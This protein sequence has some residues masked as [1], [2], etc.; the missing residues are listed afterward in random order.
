MML[1]SQRHGFRG[2]SRAYLERLMWY[3]FA[4]HLL[5]DYRT[6]VNFDI[7]EEELESFAN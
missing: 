6:N 4:E 7:P 3:Y 1:P 2:Y 5:G